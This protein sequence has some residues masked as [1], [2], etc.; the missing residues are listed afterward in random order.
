MIA[1]IFFVV[2]YTSID[3]KAQNAYEKCTTGSKGECF[4]ALNDFRQEVKNVCDSNGEECMYGIEKFWLT[5]R[6]IGLDNG[7]FDAAL[8]QA[9]LLTEQLYMQEETRDNAV[10][11]FGNVVR[12]P[13]EVTIYECEDGNCKESVWRWKDTTVRYE[14]NENGT[15]INFL[16]VIYNLDNNQGD[17]MQILA[18]EGGGGGTG[19]PANATAMGVYQT[20]TY[21]NGTNVTKYYPEIEVNI[22]YHSNNWIKLIS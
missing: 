8:L 1:T 10:Y 19:P 6:E 18:K 22:E 3:E 20:I 14:V 4:V 17:S 11:A 21:S 12:G 5:T 2:A 13:I 15:K 9:T 7:Y 16:N